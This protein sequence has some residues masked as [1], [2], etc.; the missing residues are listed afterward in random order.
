MG[1]LSCRIRH[2]NSSEGGTSGSPRK[3][4]PSVARS[5]KIWGEAKLS[6]VIGG[7][8]VGGER[9]RGTRGQ[10]SLCVGRGGGSRGLIS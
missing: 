1:T 2:R 7:E 3:G 5:G 4:P 6:A 9:G 10:C 8:L